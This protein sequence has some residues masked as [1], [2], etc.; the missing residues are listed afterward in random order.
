M[1]DTRLSRHQASEQSHWCQICPAFKQ[2]SSRKA[3][4]P[5]LL[6][7]PKIWALTSHHP[8]GGH[9]INLNF[10]GQHGQGWEK[11]SLSG[12]LLVTTAEVLFT[13]FGQID[14][15]LPFV[16]SFGF[17]SNF[18]PSYFHGA[19]AFLSQYFYLLFSHP[20]MSDSL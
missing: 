19:H 20:V 17:F 3:R 18:L 1:K 11:G 9:G 2:E 15:H 14:T 10:C 8:G 13:V 5:L 7:H 12:N 4:E 16:A 6:L